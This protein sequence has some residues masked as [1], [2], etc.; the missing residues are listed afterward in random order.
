ML[1]IW[2]GRGFL[3]ALFVG[4]LKA[5]RGVVPPAAALV[6]ERTG[7][8]ALDG[9]EM[10][11]AHV[12]QF[13][14]MVDEALE[15][16]LICLQAANRVPNLRGVASST[17]GEPASHRPGPHSSSDHH[18]ANHAPVAFQKN[19]VHRDLKLG[20]WCSVRGEHRFASVMEPSTARAE[21]CPSARALRP[22]GEPDSA[23]PTSPRSPRTRD[24]MP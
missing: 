22:H 18:S 21:P 15:W 19:V 17:H 3:A 10:A 16:S 23:Q 14:R 5:E 1:G 8:N 9:A 6:E 12:A 20:T 4:C 24:G 2:W 13:M 11:W 7:V